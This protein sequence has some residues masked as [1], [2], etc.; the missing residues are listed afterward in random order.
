MPTFTALTHLA[1]QPPAQALAEACEDL[2]PEPVGTGIF[3]IEDGSHR[4]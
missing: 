3:E 2:T 4:W 1:G